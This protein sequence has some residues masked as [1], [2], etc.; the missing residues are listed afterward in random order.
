MSETQSVNLLW[1]GSFETA[2]SI[3]K[4]NKGYCHLLIKDMVYWLSSSGYIEVNSNSAAKL[5]RW[6]VDLNPVN[7]I[8][9]SQKKT[10]GPGKYRLHFYLSKNKECGDFKKTGNFGVRGEVSNPFET[11]ETT[12]RWIP[13]SLEFRVEETKE[14]E[15]FFESTTAGS[16][17]PALD[18]ISVRLLTPSAPSEPEPVVLTPAPKPAEPAPAPKTE[19]QGQVDPMPIRAV[20]APAQTKLISEAG[21]DVASSPSDDTKSS[22]SSSDSSDDIV[23]QDITDPETMSIKQVPVSVPADQHCKRRHLPHHW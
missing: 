22:L 3:C 1:N 15:V 19:D 2:D 7:P 16:C 5:G 4:S 20:P 21:S 17:G 14:Y 18:V 10:L 8:S 13:V 9:I 11:D 23:L 6:W 12:N